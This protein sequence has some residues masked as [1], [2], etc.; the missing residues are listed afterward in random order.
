MLL[1]ASET[2]DEMVERVFLNRIAVIRL[3]SYFFT[4]VTLDEVHKFVLAFQKQF[5]LFVE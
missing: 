1:L 2:V 4:F 5:V 3:V